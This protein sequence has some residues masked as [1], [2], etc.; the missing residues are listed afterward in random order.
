MS[1][2]QGLLITEHVKSNA[3]LRAGLVS[4]KAHLK[5]LKAHHS[6]EDM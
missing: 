3:T 5:K 1:K 6:T 4:T 2:T